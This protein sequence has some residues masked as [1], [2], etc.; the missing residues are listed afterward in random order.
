MTLLLGRLQSLQNAVDLKLFDCAPD[1]QK[2]DVDCFI[3]NRTQ[4][5]YQVGLDQVGGMGLIRGMLKMGRAHVSE[6]PIWTSETAAPKAGLGSDI[7]R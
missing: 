1:S 4:S 7:D 5:L 2:V 3:S 6:E